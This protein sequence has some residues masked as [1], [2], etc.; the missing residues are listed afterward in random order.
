MAKRFVVVAEEPVAFWK[1]K[2]WKVEEPVARM[3]ARVARALAWKVEVMIEPAVMEPAARAVVEATPVT[4]R[5]EVVAL[6]A[7]KFVA[8][9]FVVVAKVVEA[10]VTARFVVVA[11]VAVKLVPVSVEKKPVVARMREEKK[12]VVVAFPEVE[13]LK[14]RFWKVLDARER[15]PPVAV[16]RPLIERVEPR[17]AAPRILA[18][19]VAVRFVVL[20]FVAIVVEATVR[21]PLNLALPT[22]S[23]ML[24]VVVVAEAPI[25]TTF[26]VFVV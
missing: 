26:E 6:I 10:L 24:P 9:S 18:V 14:V 5:Y 23:K 20:R 25:K 7:L 17:V 4:C 19:P 3:L 8:K 22:T 16:V 11:F 12:F 2:F 1:V 21:T 13:L 15:R